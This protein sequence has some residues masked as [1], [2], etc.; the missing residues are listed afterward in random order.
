[1]AGNI[2]SVPNTN[3]PPS[4]DEARFRSLFM[5][6]PVSLWEEDITG[7]VA[8]LDTLRS[9]GIRDV[10]AYFNQHPEEL[11]R[12]VGMIR[13]LAVNKATLELYE[14]PDEKSLLAGLSTVFKEESFAAF[15]EI[16]IA[17]AE[18]KKE[19]DGDAV[20][21]SLRG[22]RLHVK[23]KW[24][25][26]PD[27]E[28]RL[29][30]ALIS[31]V[32]VTERKETEILLQQQRSQLEEA[33]RISHVGSWERDISTNVISLSDEMKRIF[34]I[35]PREKKFTFQM[36]LDMMHPDDRGPFQKAVKEAVFGEKPYSTEYRIVH[37]DGSTRFIHARGEAH[38]DGLG[39]PVI[40]RGIA[41]D[42]TERKKTEEDLLE[43]RKFLE[44]VIEAAPT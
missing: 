41:Q 33:Q 16:L 5:E 34:G 10:R 43:S 36:L 19:F 44:T 22:K 8:Y 26:L 20:T 12:C 1:M 18:G 24:S 9:S 11:V 2:K 27:E 30:R 13:V 14:A 38:Y 40:F 17:V 6:C 32:D 35:N 42:I 28:S 15:R 29:T 4:D 39:K 37:G 25:L 21:S 23:L 3:Q 31:V 7:L